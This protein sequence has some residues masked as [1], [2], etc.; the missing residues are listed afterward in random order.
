[1][2][3][4]AWSCGCFVKVYVCP[5]HIG[6]AGRELEERVTERFLQY[7]LREGREASEDGEVGP[8][9]DM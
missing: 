8:V 2:K 5:E 6:A 3:T 4:E 9:S 7:E 1:M